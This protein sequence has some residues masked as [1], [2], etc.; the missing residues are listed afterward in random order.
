MQVVA[1]LGRH[2]LGLVG[3]EFVWAL[4]VGGAQP[5]GAR[6]GQ[7]VVVGGHQHHRLGRHV[8]GAGHAQVGR[9]VGL[10]G[11]KDFGAQHR[12]P[13]QAGALGHAGEQVHV[14]VGQGDD[15]EASLELLQPRHAVG[16]GRQ[17]VPRAV[18]VRA[19]GL[20]QVGQAEGGQHLVQDLAVQRVDQRPGLLAAHDARHGGRIAGAPGTREGGAVYVGVQRAHL[21]HD[22]AV[23][24]DHG[25]ENVEGQHLHA[26]GQLPGGG[27]EGF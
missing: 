24:V 23:P 5:A 16:P 11:A 22:A 7:V 26:V 9:R 1:R 10:V 17:P 27:L 15:D 8:E 4:D 21:P 19:G 3:A 12:V 6:A 14:A 13:R 2:V 20:I 25:A 18:Q